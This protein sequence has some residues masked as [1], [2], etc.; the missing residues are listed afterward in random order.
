MVSKKIRSICLTT[1]AL[2]SLETIEKSGQIQY[3]QKMIQLALKNY[4]HVYLISQ[5]KKKYELADT[6]RFTHII[7]RPLPLPK[8][9]NL[10]RYYIVGALKIF[11]FCGDCELIRADGM[12]VEL[13]AVLGSM[14][15]R[16]PLV[17][18][19]RADNI[20]ILKA[21]AKSL[22][23][24]I[25]AYSLY[26]VTKFSLKRST[27]IIALTD[28]L[29]LKAVK[30]G[31]DPSKIIVVPTLIDTTTFNPSVVGT[32]IRAKYGLQNK[33]ILLYVGRIRPEKRVDNLI[34]ALK[35][36]HE[37]YEKNIYLLIV[38]AGP[39]ETEEQ[40][41][42]QLCEKLGL[43]DYII[44]AGA[45]KHEKT[46]KYYAAADIFILPSIIEGLPN[47]LLEA[48]AMGKAI[49]ATKTGGIVD[50]VK[51]KESALLVDVDNIEDLANAIIELL[52][53]EELAQR[54][55]QKAR[56]IIEEK[57]AYKSVYDMYR[58][59]IDTYIVVVN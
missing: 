58:E 46:P 47:A 25:L 32:D 18:S 20:S 37:K 38:G 13:H 33:K 50:V 3:V 6:N 36:I 17:M 31:V 7:V 22:F 41:I 42:R 9:L 2:V 19:Y 12:A 52:R 15:C 23:D 55:A 35:I 10:A 14:L 44:R 51:D 57:Y 56:K 5:D 4:D 43:F 54:L 39:Y 11:K 59:E 29:K 48:M 24:K 27:L 49:V 1:N 53:D 16:K 30:L 45:I 8:L 40:K 26:V 28:T 21:N 34:K